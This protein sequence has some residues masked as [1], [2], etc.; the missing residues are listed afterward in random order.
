MG[1]AVGTIDKE[2]ATVRRVLMLAAPVW[3]DENGRSWLAAPPLIQMLKGSARKPYPLSWQEQWRLF[4][5]LT[6]D[7][8]R[9]ALFNVNT[10]T[11]QNEVCQLR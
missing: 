5:Q 11:R 2:L 3:R 1:V 8:A 10:R 6:K 7:M 9:M 4:P